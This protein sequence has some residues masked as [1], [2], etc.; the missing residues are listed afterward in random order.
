MF[1]ID[2]FHQYQEFED[3]MRKKHQTNIKCSQN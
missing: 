2:F 3:K 1:K